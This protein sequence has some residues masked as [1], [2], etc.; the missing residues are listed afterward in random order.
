MKSTS[1]SN[2]INA[3]KK[4]KILKDIPKSYYTSKIKAKKQRFCLKCGEKFL[5]KGAYNRICEKC[6][7]TN[8][9]VTTCMYSVN[10]IS[11]DGVNIDNSK[12]H[13]LN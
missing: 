13:E 7:L 5:S 11:S 2:Y 9:R 4:K 1:N 8:E 3:R 6:G 12:L 10:G